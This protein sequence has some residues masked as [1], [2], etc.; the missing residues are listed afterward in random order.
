MVAGLLA[1]VVILG[2]LALILGMVAMVGTMV[3]VIVTV[4]VT[5]M[6]MAIRTI[7]IIVAVPT[8]PV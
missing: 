5:D 1:T 7:P 2:I 4:I 6:G 3:T 8:Q